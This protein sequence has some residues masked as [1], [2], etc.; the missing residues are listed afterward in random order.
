MVPRSSWPNSRADEV[1][2]IRTKNFTAFT[3]LSFPFEGF[4]GKPVLLSIKFMRRKLLSL[5]FRHWGGVV[6]SSTGQR[7]DERK[8]N[9]ELVFGMRS[10]GVLVPQAAAEGKKGRGK[11]RRKG[12]GRSSDRDTSPTGESTGEAGRMAT[13]ETERRRSRGAG[14]REQPVDV[15]LDL[16]DLPQQLPPGR[17][18]QRQQNLGELRQRE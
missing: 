6:G 7:K 4:Y 2:D 12:R 10:M 8:K 16:P 15:A 18:G 5:R 14:V 17:R 9:G 11:G 13:T 3:W 1:S